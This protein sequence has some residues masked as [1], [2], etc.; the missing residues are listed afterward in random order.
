MGDTS[1]TGFLKE[2]K[3]IFTFFMRMTKKQL[4]TILVSILMIGVL[5][6]TFHPIGKTIKYF[7][8]I[9]TNTDKTII[10]QD[11]I[12]HR[13]DTL[14]ISMKEFNENEKSL[15]D[16]YKE[17]GI[18]LIKKN[19]LKVLNQLQYI[20]IHQKDDKEKILDN[21]EILNLK[22]NEFLNKYLKSSD[23][24]TKFNIISKKILK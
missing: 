15:I 18:E 3:Y 20:I 11:K 22:N 2:V 13:I 16:K 1:I 10:F 23:S 14:E 17:E 24:T 7:K 8:Y 19:N 21:L 12:L 5:E 4:A 9:K 6:M